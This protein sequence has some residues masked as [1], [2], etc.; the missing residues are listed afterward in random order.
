MLSAWNIVFFTVSALEMR[1]TEPYRKQTRSNLSV[2]L[3]KVVA[4]KYDRFMQVSL[5]TVSLF[6]ANT[7][8]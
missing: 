8:A 3:T 1:K 7:L 2:L 5:Y 4:W 6:Y